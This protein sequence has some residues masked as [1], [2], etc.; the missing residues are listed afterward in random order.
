MPDGRSSL[1]RELEMS[2]PKFNR[3]GFKLSK[4]QIPQEKKFYEQKLVPT[5]LRACVHNEILT[6]DSLHRFLAASWSVQHV[7][8][9]N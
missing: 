6:R 7:G 8:L 2:C 4:G 5:P 9:P 1:P 3:P